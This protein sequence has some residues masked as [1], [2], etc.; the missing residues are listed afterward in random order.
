M[1]ADMR[2]VLIMALVL[3]V[4]VSCGKKKQEAASRATAV[5]EVLPGSVSDSMLP[6]DT[7]RSQPPLAPKS[8]PSAGK[9]GKAHASDQPSSDSPAEAD[10]AAEAP[11][12]GPPAPPPA[13]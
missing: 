7:V 5:G 2:P 8:E 6:L 9:G 4:L 3:S 12:D 11:A 10:P 1:K 13:Q